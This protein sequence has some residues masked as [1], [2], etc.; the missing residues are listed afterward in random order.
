MAPLPRKRLRPRTVPDRGR[1]R[2]CITTTDSPD[3]MGQNAK[4]C[5]RCGTR[6]GSPFPQHR[7]VLVS[8][9][10][11]D[12][13]D[14]DASAPLAVPVGTSPDDGHQPTFA[15]PYRSAPQYADRYDEWCHT[16][17]PR[18]SDHSTPACSATR[19]ARR[20]R[21]NRSIEAPIAR[22]SSRNAMCIRAQMLGDLSRAARGSVRP[23]RG[24]A[25]AS[26]VF[27]GTTL[28]HR[29][30]DVE[31]MRAGPQNVS[32]R[33][34]PPV[35]VGVRAMSPSPPQTDVARGAKPRVR[36]VEP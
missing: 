36:R 4:G 6:K 21:A 11:A 9:H 31:V 18:E 22:S 34:G 25:R 35:G 32:H 8:E 5:T 15:F 1:G 3:R 28:A 23:A 10:R 19:I 16:I 27:V 2:P 17:A 33:V 12:V 26:A 29:A 30:D 14:V 13:T 7:V 24:R 20:L